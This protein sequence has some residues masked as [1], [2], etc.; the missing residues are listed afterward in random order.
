MGNLADKIEAYIKNILG[1]AE[2]GYVILQRGFLAERFSCAPSQI[3]YVLTTRFT[4]EKGYMV[5][6]RRGGGGYLRIVRLGFDQESNYHRLMQELLGEELSQARAY[7]LL[8]NLCEEAILSP[9]ET[10]LFKSIFADKIISDFPNDT[11]ASRLRAKM[12]KEILIN[13]SRADLDQPKLTGPQ[14]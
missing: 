4:V 14:H 6:S 1:Q 12:I 5:E 8:E 2:G 10:V 3:N 13:L 11:Y 7:N 9:R